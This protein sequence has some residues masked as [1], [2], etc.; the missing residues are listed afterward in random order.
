MDPF[1]VSGQQKLRTNHRVL[2]SRADEL[3]QQFIPKTGVN[4]FFLEHGA[5]TR[6]AGEQGDLLAIDPFAIAHFLTFNDDIEDVDPI[7]IPL[8]SNRKR[9][10]GTWRSILLEQRSHIKG[11]PRCHPGDIEGCC[12]E[13]ILQ[14]LVCFDDNLVKSIPEL[15]RDRS[16]RRSDLGDEI[17]LPGHVDG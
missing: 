8:V 10:I 3:S 7:S 1:T 6:L 16:R 4:L 5:E 14:L 13:A 17:R 9:P 12:I 11:R 2:D 15:H